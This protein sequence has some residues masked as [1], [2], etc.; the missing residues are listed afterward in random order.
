MLSLLGEDG[1]RGKDT[2][3]QHNSKPLLAVVVRPEHHCPTNSDGAGFKMIG[4]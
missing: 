2:S 3:R 1:V 4:F